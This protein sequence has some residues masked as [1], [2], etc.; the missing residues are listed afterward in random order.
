MTII[1]T[2]GAGFIGSHLVRY[3]LRRRG[4]RVVCVDALTYAGNMDNLADVMEDERFSFIYGDAADRAR[5]YALFEALRPDGVIHLAAESHVDRSI[6]D[7]APFLSSN[8]MGTAVL[9]DACRLYG[10]KRFHLVSTDEV[11]GDLPLYEGAPFTEEAPL[12]PSS[13]YA[14]TKAAADM[15]TLAWGRTYGLGVSISRCSN[16]YGSHQFPEK[17]IPLT[18]SR[19]LRGEAVP[20]YGD[21]ENVRDWLSVHDHCRAIEAVWER[22]R[23]G[24]VYNVSARA[25]RSNLAVVKAILSILGASESLISF[26]PDRPGH[27][28]RYALDPARLEK[29]TGWQGSGD[30][31]KG[32]A[33]TVSWY[34]DHKEWQERILSGAYKRN[35]DRYRKESF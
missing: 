10:V 13:P 31:E 22:G 8:V 23:E 30:F 35:N 14:A 6:A 26:V 17:L 3:W 19:A 5:M 11:Y 28:R 34:L 27:D 9:L 25:E 18:I 15:M 20:V 1:I 32:L 24:A 7:S 2:G 12:R 21:G 16:N 4:D 33:H 29:D